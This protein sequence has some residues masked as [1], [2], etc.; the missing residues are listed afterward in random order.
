[1]Y[2]A[3]DVHYLPGGRAR[4]ALVVCPTAELGEVIERHTVMVD[5]VAEYRPGNFYERELPP[6]RALLSRPEVLSLDM[7]V[8]DGYVT[9]DPAGSAGLGAHAHAEGL[10][11][12]VLGVAK[13]RFGPAVHAVEVRRGASERP[14]YVTSTGI[15]T[16]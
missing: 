15:P 7:L 6:L 12:V 9:L 1:R 8:V 2:G 13:T 5:G 10:A 4:A 16:A 3:V 11:P 14:L